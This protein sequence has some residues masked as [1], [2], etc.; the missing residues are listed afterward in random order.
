MG[1][2]EPRVEL[3]AEHRK[4]SL[5]IDDDLIQSRVAVVLPAIEH[6]LN[7]MVKGENNGPYV[8]DLNYYRKERER[9]I[10]ELARAAAHKAMLTKS[11]VE[12]PPMNAYE[13]RLIHMEITTHPELTTESVG[14]NKERRVII[15]H[16]S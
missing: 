9:L 11:D 7:L 15:K 1:F 13:R 12:L 16:I 10:T 5:F 4:I 3:D 2:E 14:L 6:I 8:V